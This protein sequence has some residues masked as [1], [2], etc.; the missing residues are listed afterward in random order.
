MGIMVKELEN[1]LW[2]VKGNNNTPLIYVVRK[3]AFIRDMKQLVEKLRTAQHNI[4]LMGDFNE[5]IGARPEEMAS[6]MTA[7]GLTDVH[8]FRHGIDREKSTYARGSRRVDYI[9]VSS[10]L[11]AHVRS[12]GAEPFNFRIFSDHRGLFVDFALPGFFDC[13]PNVL[14]KLSTRDLIYDCPQHVKKYLLQ[15]S[16]YLG[17]HD[18]PFRMEEL[19]SGERDDAAAEAIDQ[20]ITR[21]MLAAEATCKSNLLQYGEF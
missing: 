5:L 19:L 17:L 18:I 3:T 7:G 14:A 16:K 10:R 13:A 1:Y 8:C 6:V 9:L 20:D 11:T 12:T 21:S 4:L 15:A 2:Q